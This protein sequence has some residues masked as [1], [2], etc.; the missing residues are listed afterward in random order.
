MKK[1]RKTFGW[2]IY[3][4]LVLAIIFFFKILPK[5]ADAGMN[6]V[7]DHKPYT[8]SARAKTLHASMRVADLH[9]D[10]LLWKRNPAKRHVYGQTDL[11][12]FREGSVAV[13]VFSTVTFVPGNMNTDANK[14]EKDQMPLLTIAQAWPPRTW[15]SIY[16]RAIYQAERLHK[17][18]NNSDGLFV[19]A[20][21]KSDLKNAMKRRAQN[22][23]IMVGVLATE[24]AH[25]LEGD[26]ANLDKLYDAGFRMIGL[27]HF[28][29]NKLG[30]SLHG[31][32]K[33]G[34]TPFGKEVV[35]K[36]VDKGMMID[37]AHSS[38]KTVEDVLALTG[39]PIVI[40]H[41]GILSLCDHPKRNIPDRLMQQIADRGGLIGVGYWE[42]AVCDTT[43]DG[44]A[45]MLIHGA[46][47]F[48]VD[49]IALG[50][51]FDGSVT[52]ELDTSELAA[53][54]D[55]LLRQGM[56]EADIRKVMGENQIAYFLQ[57][58]PDD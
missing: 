31:V 2:L 37:V 33:S 10:T 49:H 58:L 32:S 56:S 43:P 18:Q 51:D 20:K 21:T 34:L 39:A 16:E 6:V 50:S 23:D 27:Q 1:F 7:L 13:Q 42:T 45:K 3:L 19:I 14:M 11:P 48:G 53:I 44:I 30:G 55:A 4:G 22:N 46:G 9:A 47:K 28:F 25:P 54:T 40:S 41:T 12:R 17:V 57:H 38:I 15:T 52:T 29:D 36:I 5:K 8:I 35:R 24:G 26:I